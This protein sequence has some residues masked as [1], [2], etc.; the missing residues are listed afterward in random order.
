MEKHLKGTRKDNK[1]ENT[2]S[3][4]SGQSKYDNTPL[5]DSNDDQLIYNNK[6][7]GFN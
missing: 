4:F 7:H 1:R 5:V 2:K 6:N 3:F